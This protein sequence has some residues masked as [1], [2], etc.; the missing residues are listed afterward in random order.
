MGPMGLPLH[1]YP[2]GT[3]LVTPLVPMQAWLLI[4]GCAGRTSIPPAP[5]LHQI[6]SPA[7]HRNVDSVIVPNRPLVRRRAT[8]QDKARG[9]RIIAGPNRT[10]M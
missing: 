8:V 5:E 3:S 9:L 4:G 10:G 7:Q 2:V 6:R 1:A